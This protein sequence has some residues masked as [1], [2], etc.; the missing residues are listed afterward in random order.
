MHGAMLH[1]YHA[2]ID[3]ICF[4]VQNIIAHDIFNYSDIYRHIYLLCDSFCKNITSG[5]KVRA[6]LVF[7]VSTFWSLFGSFCVTLIKI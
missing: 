3:P 7:F 5:R 1:T 4:Y 6:L 2:M